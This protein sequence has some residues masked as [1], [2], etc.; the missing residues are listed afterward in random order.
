MTELGLCKAA[1]SLP[2]KTK[3]QKRPA[4]LRRQ[5]FQ[6][7]AVLR[8]TLAPKEQ[9]SASLV[10]RGVFLGHHD[11]TGIDHRVQLV[12]FFQFHQTF[13]TKLAHVDRRLGH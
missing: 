7:L 6:T 2:S 5:A 12:A 10:L 3:T 4:F 9:A 1:L 11:S 8:L 13:D